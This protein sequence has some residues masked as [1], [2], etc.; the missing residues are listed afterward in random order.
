MDELIKQS[1]PFFRTADGQK[2]LM[3]YKAAA[4]LGH[5]E[6]KEKYE[7]LCADLNED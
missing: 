5:E 6:A 2:I 3:H 1:K 7:G 4:E